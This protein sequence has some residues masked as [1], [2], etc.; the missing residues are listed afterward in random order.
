[1]AVGWKETASR[2]VMAEVTARSDSRAML[3]RYHGPVLLLAHGAALHL[4]SVKPY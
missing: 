3:R 4:K 2:P 1:M